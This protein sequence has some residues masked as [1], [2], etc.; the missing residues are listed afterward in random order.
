MRFIPLSKGGRVNFDNATLDK[1]IGTDQFVVGGVV[2]DS[3]DTSLLGNRLRRPGKVSSFQTES[4]KLQVSSTNTDRVDTLGSNLGISRLTSKLE[5]SLLAILS[6]LG[7]S[8]V[9][10]VA[11]VS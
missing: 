2:D 8:E 9:A 7:T 1:C 10:L 5:L 11:T 6:S 3:N 4:S